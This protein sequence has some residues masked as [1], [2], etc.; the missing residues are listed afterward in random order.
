MKD[1]ST[2]LRSQRDALRSLPPEQFKAAILAIMDYEMDDV[3]TTDDP[4]AAFA[5][6]MAKPLIDKR[7]K[8]V[9]A[10]RKG[11]EANGSK[12][13]AETKQ[14]EANPKQTEA[15]EEN[16]KKKEEI[17][18][19]NKKICGRFTPPTPDEV[20]EYVREKNYNVDADKFCDFYASKG[21]MVGKNKMKDWKASVRTWARSQRQETTAKGTNRFNNFPQSDTN[22]DAL[23]DKLYA[24]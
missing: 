24:N 9:E 18:K 3:E 2:I 17:E 20:R 19:N 22:W 1:T 5:L 23:A 6:G 13:E 12:P 11:G 16:R 7:A 8:K 4:F 15:K 10:G 14:T 21:W